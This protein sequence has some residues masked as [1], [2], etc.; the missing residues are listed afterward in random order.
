MYP[1]IDVYKEKLQEESAHTTTNII[2][3]LQ[4]VWRRQQRAAAILEE[5][6]RA[7][8]L[9]KG[10]R[11]GGE[12]G[13]VRNKTQLSDGRAHR[14]AARR[15][16]GEGNETRW[17]VPISWFAAGC[18]GAH[19]LP[20]HRHPPAIA[21]LLLQHMCAIER[22]VGWC[23]VLIQASYIEFRK[24]LNFASTRMH[25]FFH[26]PYPSPFDELVYGPNNRFLVFHIFWYLKCSF[27][28]MYMS[29][30]Q[31]IR[32]WWRVLEYVN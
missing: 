19:A 28:C 11:K 17:R 20:H 8:S 30:R 29:K 9:G 2:L 25:F 27:G 14:P 1:C 31:A 4:Q 21:L 10:G 3:K 7:R 32:L 6:L 24:D 5:L 26:S 16:A 12:G 23:A 22:A 15:S 13:G 18:F